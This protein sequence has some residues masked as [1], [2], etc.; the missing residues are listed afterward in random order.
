MAKEKAVSVRN[1]VRALN[2]AIEIIAEAIEGEGDRFNDLLG[3]LAG[4]P[5]GGTAG[6]ILTKLSGADHDAAW[7]DPPDYSAVIAELQGRVDALEALHPPSSFFVDFSA[8]AST[9]MADHPWLQFCNNPA[10]L[11]ALPTLTA[12]NVKGLDCVQPAAGTYMAITNPCYGAEALEVDLFIANGTEAPVISCGNGV[13]DFAPLHFVYNSMAGTSTMRYFDT[14]TT[15][16]TDQ[17]ETGAMFTPIRKKLRIERRGS[18]ITYSINKTGGLNGAVVTRTASA[19]GTIAPT[20]FQ[21]QMS[22]LM[23]HTGIVFPA[24]YLQVVSIKWERLD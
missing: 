12:V 17:F 16:E 9:D 11:P 19:V 18:D 4:L 23:Y 24:G 8:G 20:A 10:N 13:D 1:L 2:K 22:G 3:S 7:G 21:A 14:P 5:P 6:Q 15:I